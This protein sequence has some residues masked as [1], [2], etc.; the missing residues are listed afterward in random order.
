MTS[1]FWTFFKSK[2]P[3]INFLIAATALIF[4]TTVLYPWHKQLDTDFEEFKKKT[5]KMLE[6][7]H[8]RKMEI[9]NKID[10]KLNS[11][12]LEEE[13]AHR[14]IVEKKLD[15]IMAILKQKNSQKL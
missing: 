4:Q 5:E 6:D 14:E 7:K 11:F 12:V 13:K 8:Q 9:L 1:S 10:S 3:K 15:D 2:I